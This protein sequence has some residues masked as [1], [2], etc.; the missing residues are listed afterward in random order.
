MASER[1]IAAGDHQV[2]FAGLL[3]CA[4]DGC[5]DVLMDLFGLGS[6]KAAGVR[7]NVKQI[8]VRAERFV[9]SLLRPIRVDVDIVDGLA[10]RGIVV[11]NDD[12]AVE[13]LVLLP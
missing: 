10:P 1:G 8:F 4:A 11:Q 5:R 13:F 9:Q 3:R 7:K 6:R 2:V 12:L